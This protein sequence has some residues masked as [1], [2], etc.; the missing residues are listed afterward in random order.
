MVKIYNEL[1]R[2]ILFKPSTIFNE[3]RPIRNL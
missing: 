1:K 3:Y 2:M